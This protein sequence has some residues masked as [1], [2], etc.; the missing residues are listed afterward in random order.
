[1]GK[2]FKK[3]LK[4]RIIDFIAYISEYMY[5]I[6]SYLLIVGGMA[7]I[8]NK[9]SFGNKILMKMYVITVLYQILAYVITVLYQILAYVICIINITLDG[10]SE[11]ERYI[12]INEMWIS[13]ALVFLVAFS[14]RVFVYIKGANMIYDLLRDYIGNMYAKYFDMDLGFEEIEDF[15]IIRTI[16]ALILPVVFFEVSVFLFLPVS[17]T[18]KIVIT[19]SALLFMWLVIKLLGWFFD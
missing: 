3:Y 15:P 4:E 18:F 17:L 5:G 2:V 10:P 9:V 14:V 1:M 11:T 8:L 7:I 6:I 13:L 12:A 16:I 19:I